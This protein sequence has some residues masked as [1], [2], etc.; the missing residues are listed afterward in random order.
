MPESTHS[1][2][3]TALSLPDT[4][5]VSHYLSDTT[6]V[7]DQEIESFKTYLSTLEMSTLKKGHQNVTESGLRAKK[8]CHKGKQAE[9]VALA[10]VISLGV[11]LGEQK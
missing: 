11:S 7:R 3:H 9:L 1:F 10:L 8:R 4:S 6:K 5:I 2:P